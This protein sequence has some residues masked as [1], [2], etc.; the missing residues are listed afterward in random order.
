M[1]VLELDVCP[2]RPPPTQQL[3]LLPRPSSDRVGRV[4]ILPANVDVFLGG[5]IDCELTAFALDACDGDKSAALSDNLMR[6][7]KAQS[8]R[9]FLSS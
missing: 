9:P 1:A 4:L 8:R 7:G 5:Q 3:F 2:T 6:D